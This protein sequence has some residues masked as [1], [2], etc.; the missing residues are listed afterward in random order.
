MNKTTFHMKGLALGLTLKQRRKATWKSSTVLE[1]GMKDVMI[2]VLHGVCTLVAVYL[3]QD[4][5]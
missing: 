1:R 2:W 5:F 4:P 3:L